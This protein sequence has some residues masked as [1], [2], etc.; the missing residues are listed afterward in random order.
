[1]FIVIQS[2]TS[3]P[4]SLLPPLETPLN[5]LPSDLVSARNSAT[6]PPPLFG[7]EWRGAGYLYSGCKCL[8]LGDAVK[9]N[10]QTR[11][12]ANNCGRRQRAG[13]APPPPGWDLV[14]ATY[15]ASSSVLALVTAVVDVW[16][17]SRENKNDKY[18]HGLT[19]NILTKY[20]RLQK[21]GLL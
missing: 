20:P 12:L 16:K 7:L 19:L 8:T 10:K 5:P 3:P 9:T 14:A 18:M 2:S 6:I 1:M 11:T 17:G 21:T 15:L 13:T 4:F